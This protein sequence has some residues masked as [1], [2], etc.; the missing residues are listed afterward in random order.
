MGNPSLSMC[1]RFLTKRDYILESPAKCPRCF[2]QTTDEP[3]NEMQEIQERIEQ[4]VDK[5][6][7]MMI[8]DLPPEEQREARR[9]VRRMF[10]RC[11]ESARRVIHIARYEATQ[12]GS[13]II[14]TEHILLGLIRE[15]KNLT[16]RFLRNH[17]NE[18]RN[19][20]TMVPRWI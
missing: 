15:D 13:M 12:F 17:S 9:W 7:A 11:T 14:E 6:K 1:L 16:N 4:I 3:L 2:R 8:A 18:C 19:S 10:E 5:I 20:P